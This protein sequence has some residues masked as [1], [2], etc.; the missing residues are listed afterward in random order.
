MGYSYRPI[1][2]KNNRDNKSGKH[3][4]FIRITVDRKSKYL[5]T[6][7][8]IDDN[9]WSGKENKWVKDSYPF[10]FELNSI[11]RKKLFSLQQFE[12]RQKLYGNGI[13]LETLTDHYNKKADQN[14]FN[15]YVSEFMKTV[16]GKSLNTLKKYRTFQRYLNEFNNKINFSQL[17][18]SLFQTFAAWLQKKGLVGVT[19][20]KYF[21]PF[22]V[23]CKQAVKDGYIEKD[24][25]TNISL[26]IKPTKGK[27][28]YLEIEEITKLKNKKLPHDRPDLEEA[29]KHWLF[30]FYAAF[31]Y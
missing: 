7:E 16:R 27:R 19:V 1:L 14:V 18:E 13:S 8:K 11:I 10:A 26:G 5:N 15:E 25:F 3:S 2:N 12:L 20:Y 24:P 29:R 30:C 17:N 23:I 9:F 28:V 6:G 4:I 22:K 21:D 31:Y